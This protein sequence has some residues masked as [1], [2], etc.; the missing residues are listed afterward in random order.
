LKV[1]LAGRLTAI[2]VAGFDDDP[3][4]PTYQ[5]EFYVGEQVKS[6]DSIIS[7]YTGSMHLGAGFG[8]KVTLS[9]AGCS[10]VVRLDLHEE[11][12]SNRR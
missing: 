11:D 7:P 3:S 12:T 1:N 10:M 9:R 8:G 6:E 2:K 4:A 5:V